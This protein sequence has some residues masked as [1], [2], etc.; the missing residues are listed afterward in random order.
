MP[1]FIIE[2]GVLEKYSGKESH[3]VI[4]HGIDG[5]GASAF[6]N[7]NFTCIFKKSWTG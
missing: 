3:V 1:D 2:N 4:P 5:I 6:K 7:C